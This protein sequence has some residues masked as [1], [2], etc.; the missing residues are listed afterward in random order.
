[1]AAFLQD[2]ARIQDLTRRLGDESYTAREEAEA[3]LIKLGRKVEPFV[4]A[5]LKATTDEEVRIRANRILRVVPF[6]AIF[7]TDLGKKFGLLEPG[8]ARFSLLA[9]HPDLQLDEASGRLVA[10]AILSGMR[11]TQDKRDLAYYIGDKKIKSCGAVLARMLE[12]SEPLVRISA[13]LALE[14][15]GLKDHG[16]AVARLLADPDAEVRKVA[17]STL[18]KLGDPSSWKSIAPLLQDSEA[19]VR[20]RAVRTLADAGAKD[21]AAQISPRLKDKDVK[22][23]LEAMNALLKFESKELAAEIAALFAYPDPWVRHRAREA[24]AR[25]DLKSHAAGI[26]GLLKDE[27]PEVREGAARTMID[28]WKQESPGKVVALLS[29]ADPALRRMAIGALDA[30]FARDIAGR[31]ED[32]EPRVR[33]EAADRLAALRAKEFAPGVEK[34]LDDPDAAARE[35]AAAALGWLW[36]DDKIA[37]LLA[38]SDPAVRKAG[39]L[40]LRRLGAKYVDEIAKGLRDPDQQVQRA[41]AEGLAEAGSKRHTP[42]LIK[43]LDDEDACYAA[44]AALK[45]LWGKE[46]VEEVAALLKH[47]S[48][49]VRRTV[50]AELQ[51]L[52]AKERVDDL[53]AL[54]ADPD[55]EVRGAAVKA[56]AHLLGKECVPLFKKA[57]AREESEP[58]RDALEQSLKRFERD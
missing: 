53:A 36:P 17:L 58:V 30:T 9:D 43:L 2:D 4:Q 26:A 29:H 7:G 19:E 25:L 22:V 20:A 46:Q 18:G 48:P 24:V 55:E 14:S 40:A 1:M 41:S 3:E 37:S 15:R 32:A 44:A 12:D 38:H 56:L 21:L 52:G 51:A 39:I 28:A 11:S 13:L 8:W 34:L 23:V 16:P 33:K 27:N 45:K 31:L 47:K 50:V 5:A 42:D 57:L 54:L 35:S 6:C 49:F 10:D